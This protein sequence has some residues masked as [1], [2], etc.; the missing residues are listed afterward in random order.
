[1]RLHRPDEWAEAVAFDQ[2]IRHLPGVRGECYLHR[3]GVPLDQV[4]LRT[5]EDRGQLSFAGGLFDPSDWCQP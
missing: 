2:E 5:A 1:M 3:S 4:D